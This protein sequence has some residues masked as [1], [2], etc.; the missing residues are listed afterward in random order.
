MAY[1]L[2]D[3]L[4]RERTVNSGAFNPPQYWGCQKCKG[5]CGS[6]AFKLSISPTRY[7]FCKT[8]DDVTEQKAVE[9]NGNSFIL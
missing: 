9:K 2:I 6:L 8:C 5:F 1:K 7:A 4:G 3:T